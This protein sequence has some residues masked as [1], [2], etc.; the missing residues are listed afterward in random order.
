MY[1]LTCLLDVRRQLHTLSRVRGAYD[2][3]LKA[4]E[5]LDVTIG[6]LA[7]TVG[8]EMREFRTL[9]Q[10]P[11]VF[12]ETMAPTRVGGELSLTEWSFLCSAMNWDSQYR[13]DTNEEYAT[14]L[15]SIV[16]AAIVPTDLGDLVGP[17]PAV[18]CSMSPR[19]GSPPVPVSRAPTPRPTFSTIPPWRDPVAAASAVYSSSG[20]AGKAPSLP[21]PS[22]GAYT[23]VHPL[24][25]PTWEARPPYDPAGK[26]GDPSANMDVDGEGLEGREAGEVVNN[27][28]PS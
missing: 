14:F 8:L 28:L 19:V 10:D 15:K 26:A 5:Q 27:T 24:V 23:V 1:S 4:R 21:G 6:D 7:K 2:A 3:A 25:G 17:V 20:N 9:C 11:I 16:R 13:F 22:S 18:P 12:L